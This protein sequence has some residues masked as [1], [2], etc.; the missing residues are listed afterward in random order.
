MK[1]AMKHREH[2]PAIGIGLF[3]I[4]LGLALL[5]ATN[6]LLNLGS[7]SEYF[8]WQTALIFIGVLLMLNF[9][10]VGGI[11]LISIGTW[12]FLQHYYFEIPHTLEVMYWPAVIIII[13]VFFLLTSLVG[14]KKQNS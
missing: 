2:H 10:V 9:R 1:E 7:T 11:I 12:F 13:G 8:T 4:V 14:R 5:V 6:D 3:F